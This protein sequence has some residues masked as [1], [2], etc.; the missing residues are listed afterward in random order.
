MT[1][2][3]RALD[4]I[5]WSTAVNA[6][7]MTPIDVA[8]GDHDEN[9]EKCL[10]AAI[11]AYLST[12]RPAPVEGWKTIDVPE[13]GTIVSADWPIGAFN[14]TPTFEITEIEYRRGSYSVR[15]RN[16]CWFSLNLIR[17]TPPQEPDK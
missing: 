12:A 4:P 9:Q 15:G 16:T 10:R 7:W 6:Y 5:A 17:P 14:P 13:I 8:C 3:E 2:I 1:D 11:R